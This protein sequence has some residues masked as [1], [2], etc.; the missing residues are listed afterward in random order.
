MNR[1]WGAELQIVSKPDCS[2]VNDKTVRISA[3]ENQMQE[4]I[5]RGIFIS[6]KIISS[7]FRN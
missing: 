3:A 7:T 5:K 1:V 6:L 4:A 2:G